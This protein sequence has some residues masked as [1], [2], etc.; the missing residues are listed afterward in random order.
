MGRKNPR[1][2]QADEKE[3]FLSRWSRK[4]TQAKL[5]REEDVTPAPAGVHGNC[6]SGR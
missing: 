1:E 4:K 6:F 2:P 3:G 5:G